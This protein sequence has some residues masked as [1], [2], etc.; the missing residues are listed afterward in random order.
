MSRNGQPPPVPI[1]EAFILTLGVPGGEKG[2]R[3]IRRA[4]NLLRTHGFTAA[5]T[6]DDA[7]IE[8]GDR[9]RARQAQPREEEQ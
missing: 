7:L 5:P 6:S 8:L 9:A 4:L 2:Q 3:A 1:E